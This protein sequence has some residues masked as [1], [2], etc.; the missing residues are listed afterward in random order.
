[1][2]AALAETAPGRCPFCDTALINKWPARPRRICSAPECAATYQRLYARDKLKRKY[3]RRRIVDR[4]EGVDVLE[5][6]HE[7]PRT[8]RKFKSRCCLVCASGRSQN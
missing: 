3:R 2:R 7:M 1:M 8:R 5:C 4:R 6:D